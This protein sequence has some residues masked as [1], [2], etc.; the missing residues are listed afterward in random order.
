MHLCEKE[1]RVVFECL[2]QQTTGGEWLGLWGSPR[3]DSRS[4]YTVTGGLL[5]QG[6]GSKAEVYS[7]PRYTHP[8]PP[9]G[10]RS[11]GHGPGP[12]F[13]SS[14]R[15][16]VEKELIQECMFALL[17]GS[18]VGALGTWD[19]PGELEQGCKQTQ[20]LGEIPAWALSAPRFQITKSGAEQAIKKSRWEHWGRWRTRLELKNLC[21]SQIRSREREK[22]VTRSKWSWKLS[23]C[24][25]VERL[26][27]G[28]PSGSALMPFIPG[29]KIIISVLK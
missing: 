14:R 23:L 11:R 17:T 6:I 27:C 10:A 22:D 2:Y 29:C 26:S 15:L 1:D 19:K 5:G 18:I 25:A 9:E 21:R 4:L 13:N 12:G 8:L 16:W 7:E 24:G 20:S 28:L 3:S